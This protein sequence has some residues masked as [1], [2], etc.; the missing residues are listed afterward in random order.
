M[1]SQ[2][3]VEPWLML[4][5]RAGNM[6]QLGG[7]LLAS[8]LVSAACRGTSRRMPL[9]SSGWLLAY[10]TGHAIAHWAV[11]RLGGIRFT[12]YGLH[13]STNVAWYPPGMRA[14]FAR[15]P[16]F[17]ARTEPISRRAASPFARAAMYAAGPAATA[18]TSLGISA[19]GVRAGVP[20]ARALRVGASLWMLGMLVGELAPR[21]DLRRAWRAL[22]R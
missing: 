11:G 6:V 2:D 12:G 8:R 1:T 10:F 17:S 14:I 21:S 20:G 16:F 4:S 5:V 18:L 7:L 22:R 3:R 15:M 19:L 9:L 13:G